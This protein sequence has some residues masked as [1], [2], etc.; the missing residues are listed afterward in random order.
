MNKKHLTIFIDESG[1]LP[2]P[3]G[4]VVILAAVSA[5]RTVGLDELIKKTKSK[6]SQKEKPFELKFY[7][8]GDKTKFDFFKN[9]AKKETAI[10]L[11]IVDKAKRK[12]ADTPE[13]YAVLSWLLLESIF[14]LYVGNHIII[15]DRHFHQDQ[16]IEE[17]NTILLGHLSQKPKELKHVD[18]KK[19]YLVTV[20]DM[21]AGATLAKESEKDSKFYEMIKSHII[22]ETKLN[23]PEAKRRLIANKKTRSNRC[24]HPSK[25]ELNK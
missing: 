1:T 14:N 8:A 7:T 19:N 15:F 10:F 11:L 9:L 12:I 18:S 17:F 13:N 23:W 6:R 3:Q 4:Q 5:S 22:S 24:K 16:D 25:R 21:V 2:D 20:A